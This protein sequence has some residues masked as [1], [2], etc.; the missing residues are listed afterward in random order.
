[1]K[2]FQPG[3]RSTL[4]SLNVVIVF[5]LAVSCASYKTQYSKN[6]GQW[7]D[8]AP[9]PSKKLVHTMYLVGDAGNAS[10]TYDPPILKYLRSKLPEESKRSS[11]L[12]LGDNIY[13]Y[14]MPPAED[15]I[16]RSKGE[17]SIKA[18]LDILKDFK[19]Y[20]MFIPGNHDWRGWG[21]KGLKDQEDF[22]EA[23]I[24]NLRGNEDKDDWENYFLPDN[25]CSGPEV[26]ELSND[27]VVIVVDS[28]WWLTDW[29]NQPKL[30]EGCEA[31]NRATFKFIF[32][33]VV[34]KYRNKSVVIAMHH[35]LYTYGPHGGGYSVKQTIFPLTEVSHNLYLPTPLLG[36]FYTLFRS[37]IGSRQDVANQRYK[38]LRSA[39]LAGVKKNGKFIF[40]SGHEHGLQYIE[41][42]DQKFII[43]GSGS[44]HSP[45]KLGKGSEFAT[46]SMGYSTL[47][48]YEGGETWVQFWQ[49]NDEGTQSTLVYQK[50]IKD[51]LTQAS[52]ETSFDFSEYQKHNTTTQQFL[53]KT[54]IEP[55]NSTHKF[56]FGEHHRQLYIEKYS[57]PVLDIQ[58]FKG[59]VEP[60][61]QGGGNQT[62]SLR[63]RDT[64]DRDYVL[65]GMTKDATRFLPFPFNRMVAAKYLVED[66]FLSTHPFAP[67]AVPALADAI[68]VYHTN[69]A[70]YYVPAQPAL[71]NY[72]T[73]FGGS[74]HLVE[75]RPAGKNWK[76]ADFFGNP[77]N[78]VGTPDLVE[79][80]L[81]NNNHKVD[82]SWALRTRLLDFLIGDWDRH[83]DQ[84]TW[85]VIKQDD[86]SKLY[87]P[88]PRDRD[89]AFSK[90]DGAIPAV[91]RQ[92]LPFLRQLQSYDPEISSM[93]W[94][95]WSARLFDRTFLNSLNWQ[96]WKE[97]VEFIQRNLTDDV[98]EKAFN[99][100]PEKVKTESAPHEIKSLK[101]RRDNL[102]KIARTHYEFLSKSVNVIGTDD[103]ERFEIERIDSKHTHVIV[104]ELSKKGEPKQV[105]YERIFE[106][107][108]TDEINI[109]GNGN[110]D[111][112]L[113][114]GN[115]R[116]GITVRL[117][118]GLG[119]DTFVDKSVVRVGS[120][121]TRVY[122]DMRTNTVVG[123]AETKDKRTTRYSFNI[124]DRR[125]YES[126]YDLTLPIPV[127][128]YNPDDL[129]MIGATFDVIKHGF[130]KQP[131]SSHQRFG[132]RYA[133]GTHAFMVDYRGD[134]INAIGRWD[135]LLD[136]YHHGPT[137]TFNFSGLG[138]S[139]IRDPE[140]LN[141]YRVRQ[142]AIR[143]Y[144]ALKKRF[145]GNNG[146]FSIGPLIET[147]QIQLT[148]G[149]FIEDYIGDDKYLL[150][151]K[152]FGGAEAVINVNSVDNYFTPHHGIRFITS[153]NW[154]SNISDKKDFTSW[155]A[156][157]SFY[158]ALDK[159]ENFVFAT[160]IG[161]AQTLG[162]G[163]TFFQLP[164][165]GG[166]LG[167]RG[168]H[169]QRFYGKSTYWQSTDLRVRISSSYNPVLPLT[170]GVFGSYDYGR[171]WLSSDITSTWHYSYGGGAWIAPVD[172]LLFSLGVYVP[173]EDVEDSPRFVFRMGF[174]F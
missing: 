165:I 83:D 6:G 92:T 37:N 125:S 140:S 40:A 87:R 141:Y 44:K 139:S 65:R 124:Y 85:A 60:V 51:Q 91:A 95:T 90:Y 49:V 52:E 117:I 147:S 16:P 1:M 47:Q 166:Q 127:I 128:G 138:N 32:E 2:G 159:K 77:D 45:V 101:A 161:G 145:A 34:R 75:E 97:Q 170:F 149:R 102:M 74:V 58:K 12:F 121:K 42:E 11:I 143:I 99:A 76:E 174:G 53:T 103:R 148:P 111:E 21:L 38:E 25:G 43:S 10:T 164:N 66:N 24:N 33:N 84:W 173:R 30:N 142:S 61:K 155:V 17:Y 122:D 93:K 46:G 48:F 168:Y 109:Y 35:P 68:N 82:E 169:N 133:F 41:N 150:D 69:P 130:K 94:T 98:I 114:K 31:R 144:P 26:V 54:K 78:I 63:V 163:Y 3:M 162:T 123:D 156:H 5:F 151:R 14:G 89:Q 154:I 56:F 172:A 118:G 113:V 115:V 50:K 120:K 137:Y 160:Q 18:Q 57:F 80:I 36:I 22:V 134:F 19:G 96:Q 146:Y 119:K 110:D 8:S 23:Y 104:H 107:E 112:F 67:L 72:N 106:N 73:I 71:G 39:M 100:W 64:L 62:N 131:Y 27:I 132:A 105:T 153:A 126:E 13:E 129:F 29:D 7:R 70:L 81:K 59:G 28:E 4:R 79:D 135:F 167:L 86:G 157:L 116:K 171:V 15:S 158:K 136:T 88:I 9:T 55:V 108:L 152:Y 20:P